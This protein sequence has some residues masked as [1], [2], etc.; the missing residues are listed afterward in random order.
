MTFCE[1]RYLSTKPNEINASLYVFVY[2]FLRKRNT[3]MQTAYLGE[4]SSCLSILGSSAGTALVVVNLARCP[5]I[6]NLYNLQIRATQANSRWNHIIMRDDFYIA[7]GYFLSARC[8]RWQKCKIGA[9]P[10]Y[11]RIGQEQFLSTR[12]K[13]KLMLVRL[14]QVTFALM[15]LFPQSTICIS[16]NK[17]GLLKIFQIWIFDTCTCQDRVT[18]FP[19][20][21]VATNGLCSRLSGHSF[22]SVHVL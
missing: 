2:G 19:V 1:T 5:D 10:F 12:K 22:L 18:C 16:G 17:K 20:S 21:L 6:R 8:E 14:R 9:V 7:T 15:L 13:Q 11:G 4:N 3:F